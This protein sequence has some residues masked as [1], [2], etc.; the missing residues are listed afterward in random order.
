MYNQATPIIKAVSFLTGVLI[1]L[2]IANT[3]GHCQAPPQSQSTM[4]TV[5]HDASWTGTFS[6]GSIL[7]GNLTIG[8]Y[9]ANAEYPYTVNYTNSVASVYYGDRYSS[10]YYPPNGGNIT[11]ASVRLQWVTG[12]YYRYGY[13]YRGD[14][15]LLRSGDNNYTTHIVDFADYSSA[16]GIKVRARWYYRTHYWNAWLNTVYVWEARQRYYTSATYDSKAIDRQASGKGYDW[17]MIWWNATTPGSTGCT[18]LVRSSDTT[19]FTSPWN[20]VSNYSNLNSLVGTRRYIQY[21]VYLTGP[22]QFLPDPTSTPTFNWIKI[23]MYLDPAFQDP[24][25]HDNEFWYD[26]TASFNQPGADFNGGRV[27][28]T[29]SGLKLNT[30]I[31]E[32]EYT[33]NYTNSTPSVNYGDYYSSTYYPPNGGTITRARVATRW[34]GGTYYRYSYLYSG[35]GTLLLSGDNTYSSHIVDFADFPASN[36]IR[37]RSR[38]RYYTYRYATYLYSVF[39]NESR[40]YTSGVYTSAPLN[41]GATGFSWAHVSW[42]DV[43]TGPSQSVTVQFRAALDN[44]FTTD[45]LPWQ[46]LPNNTNI[47]PMTGAGRPWVQFRI[48]LNG[49]NQAS[50]ELDWM[51]VKYYTNQ[52]PVL[53]ITNVL[54]GSSP[55]SG[56]LPALPPDRWAPQDDG[57]HEMPPISGNPAN[58]YLYATVASNTSP[59]GTQLFDI[60]ITDAESD[61][62]STTGWEVSANFTDDGDDT[63]DSWIPIPNTDM[64]WV[65]GQLTTVFKAP[66]ATQIRW[67][68]METI[69]AGTYGNIVFRC[70]ATDKIHISDPAT[71]STAFFADFNS[72]PTIDA[73]SFA[74]LPNPAYTTDTLT[75]NTS[76]SATDPDTA[77]NLIHAEDDN[78]FLSYVTSWEVNGV[79]IAGITTPVLPSNYFVKGDIVTVKVYP[80]D[81]K[82]F[83]EPREKS[84]DIQN[85]PPVITSIT[86]SPA[87]PFTNDDLICTVVASDDDE[88][89]WR[90]T[91]FRSAT[92]D[93]LDNGAPYDPVNCDGNVTTTDVDQDNEWE[94]QLK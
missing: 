33:I 4:S 52:S 62:V 84:I 75:L 77:I 21:R 66:G 59:S 30:Y 43:I 65:D 39:V 63:N 73:L 67:K 93:N 12:T 6:Q 64:E 9:A 37:V 92:V 32:Q 86:L 87:T 29:G 83:G 11:R 55:P 31:S 10:T 14:N 36:G 2:I 40:H 7:S 15:V 79:P 44:T 24:E 72:P 82:E 69:L 34:Q 94:L 35:T 49:T 58:D 42:Q 57:W 27:G 26:T 19:T 41:F 13:L 51:T 54:K 22:G 50:P 88:F 76:A 28:T 81:G 3:P 74:I 23:N 46:N 68:N 47:A 90:E 25:S 48:T 89:I 61:P 17:G 78:N 45:L 16:I 85:K 53:A 38:W 71:R 20:T 8:S 91:D 56:S 70:N 18:V 60:L 5:T 1:I 80:Y